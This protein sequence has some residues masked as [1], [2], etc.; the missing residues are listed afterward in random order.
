MK[1]VGLTNIR[2]TQGNTEILSHPVRTA[3]IKKSDKCWKGRKGTFIWLMR[4]QITSATV[5][6]SV[7]ISQK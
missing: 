7:E 6:V 5:E 3:V 1:N 2:E 4:W